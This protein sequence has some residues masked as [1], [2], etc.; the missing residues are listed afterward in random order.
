MKRTFL[1]PIEPAEQDDAAGRTAAKKK[2]PGVRVRYVRRVQ[3]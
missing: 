3:D 2:D 1:W